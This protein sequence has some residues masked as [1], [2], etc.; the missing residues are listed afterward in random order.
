MSADEYS[1]RHFGAATFAAFDPDNLQHRNA[2]AALHDALVAAGFGPDLAAALFGL[3]E[4]ASVRPSR[5][6]YYDAFVLPDGAAGSAARFF[7]LHEAQSE[8]ELRAWL[9]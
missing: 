8:A 5:T 3:T 7:V 2:A 4:I 6:A 9:S 1:A